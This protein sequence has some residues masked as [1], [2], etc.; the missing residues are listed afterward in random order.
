MIKLERKKVFVIN[1]SSHDY[2]QAEEFGKLVFMT[3]G[4]LNRFAVSKMFRTFEPF[5]QTS[6][7]HDYLLL[8]GLSVMCSVASAMFADKHG[9]L[10]LLIYKPDPRNPGTYQERIIL[11][12]GGD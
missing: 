5:I 8:S 2:S 3:E 11:M 12:K 6:K 10:N 1:R 9:R 7:E 4:S